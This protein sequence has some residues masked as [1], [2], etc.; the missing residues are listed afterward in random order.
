MAYALSGNDHNDLVD[1]M[2]E[3]LLDLAGDIHD[4][5]GELVEPIKAWKDVYSCETATP[6]LRESLYNEISAVESADDELVISAIN[7]YLKHYTISQL[8]LDIMITRQELGDGFDDTRN[9]I[10]SNHRY[11][12][13]NW[14]ESLRPLYVFHGTDSIHP[15]RWAN[16]FHAEK[17]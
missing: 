17:G 5:N 13:R 9:M 7:E 4:D 14:A 6:E 12:L 3:E 1:Q 8:A 15:D 10:A 11:H 2:I 16:M